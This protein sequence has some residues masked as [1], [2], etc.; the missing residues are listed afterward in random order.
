MKN[1]FKMILVVGAMM[2]FTS[3]NIAL[4]QDNA[5]TGTEN[6]EGHHPEGQAKDAAKDTGMMG[7][8]K[9]DDMKGMMHECMEMHKDGKMCDH[10]MMNKCQ[11][12]MS[13][14]ECDKMMKQAKAHEKATKKK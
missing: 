14:G 7:S 3:G 9:M 8:M 5:A 2:I 4:A 11:E 12:K 10:D 13:K 1:N 6:H